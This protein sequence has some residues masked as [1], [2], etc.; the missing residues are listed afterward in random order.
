MPGC[1][2]F[3]RTG[4]CQDVSVYNSSRARALTFNAILDD[5]FWFT[6]AENTWAKAPEPRCPTTSAVKKE[7]SRSLIDFFSLRFCGLWHGSTGSLEEWKWTAS[8]LTARYLSTRSSCI[9]SSRFSYLYG[10][11]DSPGASESLAG[12]FLCAVVFF[13]ANGIDTRAGFF[14]RSLENN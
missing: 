5:C 11:S 4:H 7:S 1:F 2:D 13:L 14:L 9:I 8:A 6:V 10:S 3:S 12:F